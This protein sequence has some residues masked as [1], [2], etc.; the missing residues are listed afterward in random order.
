MFCKAQ[1]QRGQSILEYALL[2]AMVSAALLT[3]N[4]YIQRAMNARLKTIQQELYETTE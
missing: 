2:V 3:M 1:D 4:T